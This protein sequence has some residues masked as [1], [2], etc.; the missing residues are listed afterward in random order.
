[1]R[2]IPGTTQISDDPQLAYDA[3]TDTLYLAHL[4]LSA[5]PEGD[6]IVVSGDLAVGS[7][8]DFSVS[9]LN[10][11]DNDLFIDYVIVRITTAE[12]TE[13]PTLDA[14]IDD[15]G[16]T[17]GTEIFDGLA[18]SATGIF[19]SR[20]AGDGGGMTK[21]ILWAGKGGAADAYFTIQIKDDDMD[22]LEAKYYIHCTG[23]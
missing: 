22:D 2:L 5:V 20:A 8:D 7:E 11:Y 4:V 1:M 19:D 10:P 17:G 9:L 6:V 14:G 16:A 12:I 15:D 21:P 3:K 13:T 23:V 18:T